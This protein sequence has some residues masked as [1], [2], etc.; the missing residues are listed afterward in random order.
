MTPR[1]CAE[2]GAPELTHCLR[3]AG[4]SPVLLG[5]SYSRPRRM[6]GR[7]SPSWR[8]AGMAHYNFKKITVVPSA[9]VRGPL[10]P[11]AWAFLARSR[12]LE[13]RSVTQAGRGR[14]PRRAPSQITFFSRFGP[15]GLGSSQRVG[16]FPQRLGL[17]G[18]VLGSFLRD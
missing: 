15:P 1:R 6:S 13:L 3:T 5:G 2:Q 18:S 12:T 4:G 10:G 7:L 11:S 8:I 14:L 16:S 17:G 9:K